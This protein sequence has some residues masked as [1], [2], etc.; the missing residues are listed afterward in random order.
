MVAVSLD[1]H[2]ENRLKALSA[3]GDRSRAV[4]KTTHRDP[5]QWSGTRHPRRLQATG[6][7]CRENQPGSRP[8]GRTPMGAHARSERDD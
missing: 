3:R 6:L 7:T 8:H 5:R 1:V 4:H 2:R